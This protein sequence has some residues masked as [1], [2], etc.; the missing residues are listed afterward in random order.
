MGEGVGELEHT[1]KCGEVYVGVQS[2]F[3]VKF[4]QPFLKKKY[5][6]SEV[7][8]WSTSTCPSE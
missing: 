3:A 7:E 8:L 1:G 2:G 4:K 6:P 5:F